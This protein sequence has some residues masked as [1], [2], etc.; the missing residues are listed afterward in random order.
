MVRAGFLGEVG[1]KCKGWEREGDACPRVV[2]GHKGG[3]DGKNSGRV[4]PRD[5]VSQCLREF[6]PVLP[7]LLSGGVG[8]S[9]AGW[10]SFSTVVCPCPHRMPL[11]R[12]RVS[13]GCWGL[14]TVICVSGHP[15]SQAW[16]RG[17]PRLAPPSQ[18]QP[19]TEGAAL[20]P[21]SL[22]PSQLPFPAAASVSGDAAPGMG[23]G[24]SS[25]RVRVLSAPRAPRAVAQRP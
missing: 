5:T 12:D 10:P 7:L 25:Q 21:T 15:G 1:V 8:V 11:E 14:A 24:P 9:G 19:P 13:L 18:L 4:S 2:G 23:T 3:R 6:P 16:S 22:S 20:R 17:P